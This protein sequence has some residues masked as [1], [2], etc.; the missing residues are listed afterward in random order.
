MFS[1]AYPKVLYLLLLVPLY[2]GLYILA[3]YS[4]RKK[5]KCFGKLASLM[6]LM[7][8]VSD[9]KAPLKICVQ[10]AALSLLIIAMARPWGGIKNQ[11]TTKEGI[12]VIIAVDASNSMLASASS[13]D[14]GTSRM[15]TAKFT[16]EKL[17]NRLD[18][19]RVG[20]IVYANSAYT[21]IPVTNDYVSAKMFLNSIDPAQIKD[22]GTNITAAIDMAMNSFSDNKNI[23]KALIL[24][25]DAE[26]LEDKE[27]VM[28]AASEAGRKGIQVDVVGVGSS[29]AVTVPEGNG[30]VM[31]DPETGSPV[32][33]ALNEDLAA[34]IAKNAKG[35]YVNASNR[36]A[37]SE[38]DRQLDTLKKASLEASVYS[39][40]DE[41]FWIFALLSLAAAVADIFLLERK[42]SW[43]DK[44]TFFKKESVKN[45]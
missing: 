45:N 12:E 37:L 15:R 16:L 2:I 19:D 41:L 43:L 1:F 44:I 23:G 6:P 27:G 32:R 28:K 18:N 3:R 13:E 42:I 9:Y 5:L 34:E 36:D 25:T 30:G 4:R 33:T 24:I 10:M 38:L 29:T 39:Q 11:K 17:I 35:I 21:L 14:N 8:E 7:P 22:Q 31:I 20:L 26:E 40:H